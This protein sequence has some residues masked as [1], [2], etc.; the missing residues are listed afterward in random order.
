MSKV[1]LMKTMMHYYMIRAWEGILELGGEKMRLSLFGLK[2]IGTIIKNQIRK[3]FFD[4]ES[5]R[6]TDSISAR[7]I[8][9]VINLEGILHLNPP[10]SN[11]NE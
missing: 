9:S 5:Y 11:E 2:N 8:V 6:L 1:E 4:D 7:V 3:F 10:Y